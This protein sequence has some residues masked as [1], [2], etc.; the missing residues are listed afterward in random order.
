MTGMIQKLFIGASVV[1]GI[2]AGVAA[3][4]F[5]AGFTVTGSDYY[6]YDVDGN[7]T[8]K[9]SNADLNEILKGDSSNPGG[10]IELFASS[11]SKPAN[12]L[13]APV[14]LSGEVGGK[15]L[16]LSS[17][18]ADDWFGA[19]KTT[20]T[21]GADNLANKWFNALLTNTGKGSLV[22][23]SS[24]LLSGKS[25]FNSFLTAGGF[26]RTSDPNISYI[27]TVGSDI[28]I[29]L[30]GHYNIGDVYGAAFNGF[31]ASEV[32][33]YTY[34][35]VTDYL[36]GFTATQ[37]GLT[38]KSDGKSHSGNY[39]VK[40]AGVIDDTASVPEPSTVLGLAAVGGLFAS[41]RRKAQK[42]G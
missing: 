8:Y 33:K 19:G 34:D 2:G 13:A 11:E 5:A 36:F 21:Y 39:E 37:S 16:T 35:G 29:G 1:A 26:Q 15:T 18:N 7:Q 20:T 12:F 4:A 22:G 40:I 14:S 10:N 24:G 32:V 38:E 41:A 30:A 27:N 23:T 17:L 31:Q 6:L 9:N 42:N 28:N 25:L 3:P